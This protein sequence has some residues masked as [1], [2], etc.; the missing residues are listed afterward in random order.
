M[1]QGLCA[2][3]APP[4]DPGLTPSIHT[5]TN[6]CLQL[7]SQRINVI[8]L[9]SMGSTHMWFTGIDAGKT[10]IDTNLKKI[11]ILDRKFKVDFIVCIDRVQHFQG[12][13]ELNINM[14]FFK[15]CGSLGQI[16]HY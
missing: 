2:L 15:L 13:V 16:N 10:F 4:E 3:A 5:I 12:P 7:Q 8:L 14:Y 1:V 6:N 9:A 11:N